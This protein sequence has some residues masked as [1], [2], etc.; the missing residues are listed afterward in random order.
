MHETDSNS[1]ILKN[2]MLLPHIT[3]YKHIVMQR[4]AESIIGDKVTG[5]IETYSVWSER[6]P[7]CKVAISWHDDPC[8]CSTPLYV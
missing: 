5:C 1:R 8:A 2:G 3:S 4:R 6:D 7:E